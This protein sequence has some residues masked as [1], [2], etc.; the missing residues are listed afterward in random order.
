VVDN[1]SSTRIGYEVGHAN[2]PLF[3]VLLVAAIVGAL[4]GWLLLHLPRR[5]HDSR[6]EQTGVH[7]GRNR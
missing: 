7:D 2:A 3:V 1:R 4:V 5:R 6:R